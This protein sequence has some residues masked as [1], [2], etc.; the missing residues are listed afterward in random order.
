MRAVVVKKTD[1][2]DLDVKENSV[3]QLTGHDGNGFFGLQKGEAD[4]MVA[5]PDAR[6]LLLTKWGAFE[7]SKTLFPDAAG[8]MRWSD[9][10][11]VGSM[12]PNFQFVQVQGLTPIGVAA[13]TRGHDPKA[14][15]VSVFSTKEATC[16]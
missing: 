1:E 10:D 2:H 14:M 6:V 16:A 7:R 15:R 13:K 5:A 8:S 12:A 9:G 3:E 4:L 11:T